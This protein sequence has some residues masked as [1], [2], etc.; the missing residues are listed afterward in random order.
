MKKC[1]CLNVIFKQNVWAS[2]EKSATETQCKTKK[3]CAQELQD[4]T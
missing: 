3:T 2:S 1:N 4:T